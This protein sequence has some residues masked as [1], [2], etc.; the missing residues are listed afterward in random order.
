MTENRSRLHTY[1]RPIDGVLNPP[2]PDGNRALAPHLLVGCALEASPLII[3]VLQEP[4]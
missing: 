4:V 3:Q 2:G 1:I